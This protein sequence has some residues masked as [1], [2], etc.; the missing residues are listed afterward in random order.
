M[1]Y[2]YTSSPGM[3]PGFGI[4]NPGISAASMGGGGIWGG[5][6]SALGQIASGALN[7]IAMPGG[8]PLGIPGIA[9]MPVPTAGGTAV[10]RQRAPAIIAVGGRAYRSLGT[11]LAWSGDL[12][13]VKRLRRAAAR[14]GHVIPKR[15]GGRFR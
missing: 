15:G 6:G 11:P 10:L 3:S 2:V 1:A 13:A 4:L 14:I 8:A 9:P 12:A 5:I 7:S